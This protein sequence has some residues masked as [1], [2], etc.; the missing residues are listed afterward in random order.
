MV[1]GKTGAIV[2]KRADV[3]SALYKGTPDLLSWNKGEQ[4]LIGEYEHK[5]KSNFENTKRDMWNT[6]ILNPKSEAD[7]N[8]PKP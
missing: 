5:A 8:R 6:D 3:V 7:F 4:K 2:G 1:H